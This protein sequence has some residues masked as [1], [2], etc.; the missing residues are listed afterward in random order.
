MIIGWI[1]IK[2][3]S[4][5]LIRFL[6]GQFNLIIGQIKILVMFKN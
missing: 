6:I 4:N 5:D 1:Y 3:K 2:I